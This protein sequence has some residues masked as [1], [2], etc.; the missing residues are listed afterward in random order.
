MD[1]P[2]EIIGKYVLP[3]FRSM[4]AKE[5]VQK[6]HLSQTAAAKK[7]GTTQAAVSQYLSSKRAYKGMEHVEEFLPKIRVMAA[8][9]AEKLVNKEISA[10]DVTVDFCR[11]CST[12]CRNN[13][14]LAVD[15]PDFSI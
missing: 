3:I 12:F 11:L 9:T 4:L 8:E 5:L 6:H 1:P 14:S 2:C 13:P 7:L 10:G 15:G